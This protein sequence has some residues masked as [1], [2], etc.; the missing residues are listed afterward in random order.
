AAPEQHGAR[1]GDG[2]H[3]RSPRRA[4]P[5]SAQSPG[6]LRADPH[7][8]GELMPM[9]VGEGAVAL[10]HV[11]RGEGRPLLLLHGFAGG[12]ANWSLVF[13]EAP[14]GYRLIA[15]DLRGHGG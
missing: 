10:H 7:T 1:S 12:G 15:P 8:S 3:R 4:S 5:A 2:G 13:P 14:A 9:A 11:E 6:R